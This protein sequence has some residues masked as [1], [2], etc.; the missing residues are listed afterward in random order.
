MDILLDWI[1]SREAI[2]TFIIVII[3][4]FV[5]LL[6]SKLKKRYSEKGK[7]SGEKA[8][9][10]SLLFS[11]LRFVIILTTVLLVLQ[12]NGI[13][14]TSMVAGLGIAS[15]IVGLALQD[16]LKDVIMGFQIISDKFFSVGDCVLYNGRECRVESFSMRA[17]KLY[18]L[19]DATVVTVSNRNI[20]EVETLSDRV[21]IT[22]PVSYT[23]KKERYDSVFSA[24]M[25]QLLLIDGVKS[26]EYRGITAFESSS[27]S[28]EIML[29][30]DPCDRP[31]VRRLSIT[32]TYE[33][34]VACGVEVPYNQ[35][36]VHI[37][38]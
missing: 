13:N 12:A 11:I 2:V 4:F 10:V 1:F 6:I 35:L 3:A 7:N 14:V 17:T 18:D 38:Q 5:M 19:K 28:H 21:F 20:S 33:H 30:C 25:S 24:L 16:F 26:A 36:D 34:L 29:I 8:T 32:K 22:V 31:A 37:K 27:L 15:A 9:A 23:E